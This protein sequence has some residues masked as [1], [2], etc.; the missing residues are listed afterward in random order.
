LGVRLKWRR[1]G[2]CLPMGPRCGGRYAVSMP[3]KWPFAVFLAGRRPRRAEG[4]TPV[5]VALDGKTVRGVRD[6]ADPDSRAPH[7]VSAVTHGD[8][9]V[10]GQVM[11]DEKS[12]RSPLCSRC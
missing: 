9:V 4:A 7:L 2:R 1:V 8:G 6:H 5:A 3:T 10:L 11:V 12:T